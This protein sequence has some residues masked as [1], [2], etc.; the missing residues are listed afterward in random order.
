MISIHEN[1]HGLVDMNSVISPYDVIL[2]L[3]YRYKW[4]KT[5]ITINR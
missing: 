2:A 5:C 1:K 4:T 3:Q